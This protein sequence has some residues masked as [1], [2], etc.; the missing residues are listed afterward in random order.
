VT[1]HEE[2]LSLIMDKKLMEEVERVDA[3]ENELK[4]ITTQ[5]FDE[6]Q[7]NTSVSHQILDDLNYPRQ[8]GKAHPVIFDP[9][10]P[11][12]DIPLRSGPYPLLSS[13]SVLKSSK[14]PNQS[15][16]YQQDAFIMC[17]HSSIINSLDC[18]GSVPWK[19]ASPPL[20]FLASCSLPKGQENH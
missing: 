1:Y 4:A 7:K 5:Q 2:W 15:P 10:G 17:S 3:T 11:W 13:V 6:E 18:Q 14:G 9:P 20:Q 8:S 12:M 16:L 19:V